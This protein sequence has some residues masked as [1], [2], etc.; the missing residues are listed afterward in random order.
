MFCSFVHQRVLLFSF[1]SCSFWWP[2]VSNFHV[3]LS[4]S[5]FLHISRARLYIFHFSFYF[6][7]ILF[8][9]AFANTIS[10]SLPPVCSTFGLSKAPGFNQMQAL[11]R[12]QRMY[13]QA[14]YML[15]TRSGITSRK[16]RF[17]TGTFS[18]GM[19]FMWCIVYKCKHTH[20]HT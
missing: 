9:A 2:V 11:Y 12:V 15:N 5:I 13:M 20:T 17:E 16:L 19:L 7:L 6:L 14:S 8:F 1:C 10:N 18:I 3:S 4:L